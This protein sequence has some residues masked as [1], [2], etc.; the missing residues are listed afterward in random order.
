M[1]RPAQGASKLRMTL[2]QE[3]GDPKP[4]LNHEEDQETDLEEES[5][6]NEAESDDESRDTDEELDMQAAMHSKKTSSTFFFFLH[7]TQAKGLVPHRIR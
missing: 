1:V 5:T 4:K 6:E 7:R 3:G 2:P